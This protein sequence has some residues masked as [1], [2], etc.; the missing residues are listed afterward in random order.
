MNELPQEDMKMISEKIS[1][2]ESSLKVSLLRVEES[3]D[4]LASKKRWWSNVSLVFMSS[5]CTVIAL[6]IG[7]F[8][9]KVFYGNLPYL[10]NFN[11]RSFM[12]LLNPFF[13]N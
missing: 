3:V 10:R 1:T 11:Y 6:T 9:S 12:E 5:F 7:A 2:L 4:S 8:L 13:L